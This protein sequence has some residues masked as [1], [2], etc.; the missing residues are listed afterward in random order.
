MEEHNSPHPNAKDVMISFH[1][2]SCKDLAVSL[3]DLLLSKGY[4]LILL[5]FSEVVWQYGHHIVCGC[6]TSRYILC[7]CVR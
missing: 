5:F 3:R 2:A 4:P 6:L 1:V 7:I